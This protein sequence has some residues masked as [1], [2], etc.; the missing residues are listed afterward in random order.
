MTAL[1][2]TIVNVALP[3][4]RVELALNDTDLKWVAAIYP[5]TL[6]SLLPLGGIWPTRSDGV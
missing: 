5:L 1:D 2:N 6:A 4:I 3:K